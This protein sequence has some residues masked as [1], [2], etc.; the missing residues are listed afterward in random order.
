MSGIIQLE[1]MN[2]IN[3]YIREYL[4]FHNMSQ[5]LENFEAEIKTKQMPK[6]L[7]NELSDKKEEPRIHILFK[8]VG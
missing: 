1:T 5:S 7:R 8:Q 6:R 3:E 4:R 2:D